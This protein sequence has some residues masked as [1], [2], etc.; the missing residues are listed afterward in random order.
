MLKSRFVVKSLF[1]TF[2]IV[3]CF[4]VALRFVDSQSLL[5]WDCV[6]SLKTTS[7]VNSLNGD[8]G[9]KRP[10]SDPIAD[11]ESPHNKK[12]KENEDLDNVSYA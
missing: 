6:R 8:N 4:V 7:S 12:K 11:G 3:L 2:E 9:R 10:N 1:S 5:I